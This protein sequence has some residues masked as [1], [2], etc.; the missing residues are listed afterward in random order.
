MTAN[1]CAGLA[2]C[3]RK[4][5]C[6][7][8]DGAIGP[9]QALKMVAPR[10]R[11]LPRALHASRAPEAAG[12]RRPAERARRRYEEGD[13]A[14]PGHDAALVRGS[15]PRPEAGRTARLR[16]RAPDDGGL[17]HPDPRPDRCRAHR[18]RGVAGADGIA[19]AES[20]SAKSIPPRVAS[21][22]H[23]VTAPP[24]R[25]ACLRP[26]GGSSGRGSRGGPDAPAPV[27]RAPIRI[28]ADAR[29]MPSTMSPMPLCPMPQGLPP[30]TAH[31]CAVAAPGLAPIIPPGPPGRTHRPEPETACAPR[32]EPG[33]RV[34]GP[35][36]AGPGR[37]S[38]AAGRHSS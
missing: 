7:I 5:A 20:A 22:V 9:N 1:A 15:T 30:S 23:P 18:H 2:R 21:S 11:P 8:S 12:G 24:V 29:G 32:I 4:Q 37:R 33:Q 31:G 6:Q 34:T 13:R 36:A 19:R 26:R 28:E 17:G 14:L 16:L 10:R 35:A 25:P 38:P 3:W 27:H